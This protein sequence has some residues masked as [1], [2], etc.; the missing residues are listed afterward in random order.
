MV[1]GEALLLGLPRSVALHVPSRD[2][3]DEAIPSL[4]RTWVPSW[5]PHHCDFSYSLTAPKLASWYHQKGNQEHTTPSMRAPLVSTQPLT[6]CSTDRILRTWWTDLTEQRSQEEAQNHGSTG[7]GH[8][9]WVGCK[10]HS[11][12]KWRPCQHWFAPCNG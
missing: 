6:S 7:R 8:L 5:G 3:E 4:T 12:G 1:S 10:E 11:Q 9:L 2:V